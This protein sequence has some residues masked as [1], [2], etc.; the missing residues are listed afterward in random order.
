[1][2]VAAENVIRPG[3]IRPHKIDIDPFGLLPVEQEITSGTGDIL[4]STVCSGEVVDILLEDG[5][6]VPK[7]TGGSESPS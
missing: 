6:F 3:E 5:Q 2:D 4:D 1:M 7:M